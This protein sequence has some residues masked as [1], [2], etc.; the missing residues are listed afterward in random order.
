MADLQTMYCQLK[1]PES[2]K[3]YLRY[4]WWKKGEM[5]S[6]IVDHEMCVHLFGAV[7]SLDS[8]NY[9][10]KRTAVGNISSYGIDDSE[11]VMKNFYVDDLLTLVESEKY[12]VDFPKKLKEM[13][14]EDSFNLTKFICNRNNVL[15]GIPDIHRR[16][17][18]KDTNLA[19]EELPTKRALGVN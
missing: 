15:I 3:S 19:K 6:E 7:S 12:T 17:G 11:T 4:H 9:P 2:Q 18:V 10:L 8:S 1:V 14:T 5:N 16:E 13:C